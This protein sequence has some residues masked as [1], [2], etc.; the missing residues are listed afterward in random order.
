MMQ[1][2]INPYQIYLC[3]LGGLGHFRGV[4]FT[5]L[6]PN[7]FLSFED[8][9]FQMIFILNQQLGL[10]LES[11]FPLDPFIHGGLVLFLYGNEK[12]QRSNT[13]LY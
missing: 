3:Q 2:V 10:I 9:L 13:Y 12:Y 4:N 6:S 1:R 11:F 8:L 5:D 7:H